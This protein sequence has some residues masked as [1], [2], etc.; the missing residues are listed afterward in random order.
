MRYLAQLLWGGGVGG[1]GVVLSFPKE[2]SKPSVSL[3]IS[4]VLEYCDF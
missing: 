3:F 4:P 1:G 2:L